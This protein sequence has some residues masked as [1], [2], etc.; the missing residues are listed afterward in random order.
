M[1]HFDYGD[2]PIRRAKKSSP[3]PLWGHR[4]P[5]TALALLEPWLSHFCSTSSWSTIYFLFIFIQLLWFTKMTCQTLKPSNFSSSFCISSS[6]LGAALRDISKLSATNLN[7]SE[8]HRFGKNK[9]ELQWFLHSS[10]GGGCAGVCCFNHYCMSRSGWTR[11]L[12]IPNFW[13]KK[14]KN[15][16]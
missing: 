14:E 11:I 12:L 10:S 16:F 1:T 7:I 2:G 9:L 3:T 4:L 8:L 15:V 5:V 13:G 6:G